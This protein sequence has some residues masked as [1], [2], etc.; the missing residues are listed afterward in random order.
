VNRLL[1]MIGLNLAAALPGLAAAQAG[2]EYLS[3]NGIRHM[4]PVGWVRDDLEDNKGVSFTKLVTPSEVEALI[5][6]E[7]ELG[8]N[9]RDAQTMLD[10][11][12][13]RR[14]SPSDQFQVENRKAGKAGALRYHCLNYR[15]NKGSDRPVFSFCAI[16]VDGTRRLFV[17][18]FRYDGNFAKHWNDV[19]SFVTSL[20]AMQ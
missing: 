7:L 12:A 13:S 2:H 10:D 17:Y 3:R 19:N 5:A 14:R 15:Q 1:L 18:S 6:L 20:S 11:F 9:D 16:P 4:N 8:I